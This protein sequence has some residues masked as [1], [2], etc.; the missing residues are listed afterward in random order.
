MISFENAFEIMMKYAP[1]LPEE[2]TDLFEAAGRIL[3]VDVRSD[4]DMPPFDKSAMDGYASRREDLGNILR[5]VEEIPAGKAPEKKIGKNQCSRIMTGAKVPQGADCVVMIEYTKNPTNDTMQFLGNNTE[6]NICY[7][8][9]DIK[10]GDIVLQK[11]IIIKPQD[12]AVL[13]TVGCATPPVYTR[14]R[15]GI[16]A[17]GD[18]L[19]EPDAVPGETQ[20][21]NSN[22]WQIYSQAKTMGAVPIYYGVAKDT[23]K[24]LD[25]KIK[26]ACAE[27]NV[28]LLSGGVSM[29]DFDL[30][31]E[32]LRENGFETVFHR[33]GI[34]P[35]RP[36]LFCVSE[37]VFCFGLPG[38]PVSTFVTFEMFVKPFLYK[39]MG[40]EFCPW[41][42]PMNLEEGIRRKKTERRSFL[43]VKRTSRGGV[44]PVDYHGSAH[45]NSL[46]G[47]DGI[48]T[49]PEGVAEIPKGDKVDVRQI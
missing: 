18:E 34:K 22:S 43:P 36:T 40:H 39:M 13:A 12:I 46:C 2:T 44:V 26:K 1:T 19:V 3:A 32:V 41:V 27:C 47:A 29:G 4:T 15:V 38:N 25:E 35:G 16:V 24:A 30:V 8:G 17:T 33:V 9:E 21:R 42:V 10:K 37:N 7:K 49:V 20:I 48:V 6:N 5:I 28:L 23:R 14:P 31:P 45:L 11:G